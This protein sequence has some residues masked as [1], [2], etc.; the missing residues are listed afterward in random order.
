MRLQR[1]LCSARK[2]DFAYRIWHLRLEWAASVSRRKNFL[3]RRAP[4][5]L[6]ERYIHLNPNRI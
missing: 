1:A 5:L 3:R 2:G 4:N 6:V